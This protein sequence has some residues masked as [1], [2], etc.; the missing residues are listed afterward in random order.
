MVKHNKHLT[1][2]QLKSL[3]NDS[4]IKFPTKY[5]LADLQHLC[6][7]KGLLTQTINDLPIVEEEV[8]KEVKKIFIVKCAFRK[9]MNFDD[10]K[11]SLLQNEVES[12]VHIISRML[13]RSSLVIS[14]HFTKMLSSEQ[15]IPNLYDQNDT[16]WKKWLCIGIDNKFPD[17]DSKT[18]FDEI[19]AYIGK[20]IDPNDLENY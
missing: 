1:V 18:S 6:E 3:L 14:Y 12:F 11:F 4:N 19:S 20:V 10:D 17:K 5:K 7:S 16:Y 8:W 15:V 2:N 9:A 13:R